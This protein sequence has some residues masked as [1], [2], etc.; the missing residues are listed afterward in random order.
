MAIA[1]PTN[2]FEAIR[3]VRFLRLF[4]DSENAQLIAKLRRDWNL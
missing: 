1:M 4:P 3:L 2:R